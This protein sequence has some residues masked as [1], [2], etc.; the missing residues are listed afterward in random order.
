MPRGLS[1][2]KSYPHIEL[3]STVLAHDAICES[4]GFLAHASDCRLLPE[5]MCTAGELQT[6]NI[7]AA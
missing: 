4:H 6:A 1:V 2:K 3:Q 7:S 5:E